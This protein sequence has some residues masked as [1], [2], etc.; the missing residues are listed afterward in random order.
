MSV[1]Q[2]AAIRREC[3]VLPAEMRQESMSSVLMPLYRRWVREGRPCRT[4][5]EESGETRQAM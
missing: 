4:S 1:P 5:K 3:I 2:E